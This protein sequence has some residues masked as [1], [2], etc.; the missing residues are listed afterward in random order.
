MQ[1]FV[2][3]D[4]ERLNQLLSSAGTKVKEASQQAASAALAQGKQIAAA[5]K[6]KV[7]EMRPHTVEDATV[8]MTTSDSSEATMITTKPLRL[9]LVDIG[10]TADGKTFD[11]PPG[12]LLIGRGETAGLIV[13]DGQVSKQHAWVGQVNGQW[14]LKDQNSSNGTFLGA[15][16]ENRV[17]ESPLMPDMVVNLGS[18]GATKF[19]IAF[20]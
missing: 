13:Q 15:D 6:S 8:R 20:A 11:V 14:I 19:K 12:G 5:A 2:T 18:H 7:E 4:G 10:G 16:L 17:Q 3:D 9:K 1:Q